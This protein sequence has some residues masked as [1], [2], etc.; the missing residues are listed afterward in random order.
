MKT[1][2]FILLVIV[3]NLLLFAACTKDVTS[4]SANYLDTL[5]ITHSL[6]GWELYSWPVGN[7]WHF[8]ILTGTNRLKTLEEVRSDNS[9]GMH[10]ITVSGTDSLK[11]VLS[12]FPENEYITMIGQ[13]WLQNCWGGNYGTLQLPPQAVIDEITQFCIQ[14][15]LNFQVT[16]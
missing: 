11:L 6:K 4:G 12:K 8:S 10:W 2:H 3:I 5:K 13:G 16:D 15:K 7:S 9:T 1:T 14:N